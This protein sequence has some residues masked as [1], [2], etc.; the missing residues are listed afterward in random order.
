MNDNESPPRAVAALRR[1]GRAV[2]AV[3]MTIGVLSLLAILVLVFL[4]AAQ[5]YLPV[6]QVA[7]T[8][9][10][11]RFGLVWLTFAA[12]GLLVTSRGHIA[13]EIVDTIPNERIV[14]VVQ[15]FALIVLTVIGVGLT[16]EAWAL[17]QT[18]GIIR[19]PVL[20]VPMSLV[21]LPV[22]LGLVS[23][24]VRAAISAV[25]VILHGPVI[26]DPA[27]DDTPEQETAS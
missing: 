12:A 17:V 27:E 20:R 11:S 23:T 24:T 10:I 13:L 8:G 19:S 7:W 2:G 3:E 14:R 16:L 15:A 6:P 9:E 4:Q 18:Q 26:A 5:R 1:A 21:Y 22:L 25:E